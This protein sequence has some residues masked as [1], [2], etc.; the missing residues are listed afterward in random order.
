MADKGM[1]QFRQAGSAPTL[2]QVAR[3]FGFRS[4]ELDADYG[5]VLVEEDS[6]GG[7]YVVLADLAAQER[8]GGHLSEQDQQ[9]PAV[10]FFANPRVEPFGPPQ[11]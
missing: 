7:L 6:D 9:D 1:F 8:V 4:E 2:E 11:P 10:G 5:V 3:R